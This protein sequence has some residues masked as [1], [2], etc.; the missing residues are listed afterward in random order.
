MIKFSSG[1]TAV[2]EVYFARVLGEHP[3]PS[4]IAC[5]AGHLGNDRALPALSMPCDRLCV[6]DPE[7]SVFHGHYANSTADALPEGCASQMMGIGRPRVEPSFIAG[8][9][10]R[11]MAVSDTDLIGAMRALSQVLGRRVGGSIG[12]NLVTCLAIAAKIVATGQS[13][14]IV[15]LLRSR[16]QSGS[17]RP[18]GRRHKC[19]QI[20]R[21]FPTALLGVV[22][23]WRTCAISV[24]VRPLQDAR[25]SRA[26]FRMRG[27]FC[28]CSMEKWC[29]R[30]DSNL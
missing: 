18:K 8:V 20:A 27:L 25:E 2:S 11:M 10:N 24:A 21:K 3:V 26:N 29:R 9:I 6:A 30:E 14:S 1:S 22:S 5:G 4:W 17:S 16:E 19:P 15:A 13:G 12:T 7:H 23:I 28:K